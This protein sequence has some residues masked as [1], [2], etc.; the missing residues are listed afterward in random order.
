MAFAARPV[1]QTHLC[2]TARERPR[3]VLRRAST[4]TAASMDPG[5]DALLRLAGQAATETPLWLTGGEPC[6]RADLPALISALAQTGFRVGMVSDGET[7]A[8]PGA[9]EALRDAGLQALR[10][11][12]H[13]ARAD[14]HDWLVGKPGACRSVLRTARRAL[15]L[16]FT[17]EIGATLTRPTA[18]HLA[19]WAQL[20]ARLGAHAAHL[21][22]WPIP[23]PG[24]GDAI[25]LSPRFGLLEDALE[26][27]AA[28]AVAFELPLTLWGLP[29]CVA[30]RLRTLH[31]RRELL[32]PEGAAFATLADP[33]RTRGAC[34]A[35]AVMPECE[36]AP[37]DYLAR[38]GMGEFLSE[39]ARAS[40]AAAETQPLAN[41]ADGPA[42]SARLPTY[43]VAPPPPRALRSPATRVRYGREQA[44]A[45]TLDGDP[46]GGVARGPVPDV[47]RTGWGA[48]SRVA[49]PSCGD[50]GQPLRSARD[51]R[52][53]L[54]LAAQQGSRE[55][56]LASAD[57]FS[58]PE[59]R[60]LLPDATQLAFEHVEVAGEAGPLAEWRDDELA[61]L[62]RF[63]RVRAALYGPDARLHDRHMQCEGAFDAALT[64]LSRLAQKSRV[65]IGCYAVLH[66]PSAV[67]GYAEAWQAGRLP[68]TPAFRL[69]PA[70]SSLNALARAA[71]ELPEGPTRA[72]LAAVLPPCLLPRAE[73]VARPAPAGSSI[74]PTS[75]HT[76]AD[77]GP[78]SG[79][80]PLG[81]FL[82][83]QCGPG[84]AARCPGRAVG[85][86][87]EA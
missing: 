59:A 58:H 57:V 66:D 35:C 9:L 56:R 53:L 83:C 15:E 43:P 71:A 74:A 87:L 11:G 67:A 20:A 73:S 33:A 72:A 17:V 41:A 42:A 78:P 32:L 70:G 52:R 13:S 69:S 46:I 77:A 1:A 34:G 68:G 65:E 49:C 30:P 62:K 29:H 48:V 28:T 76:A 50:A 8:S 36:G 79:S 31:G 27:A 85:W 80:D 10:F 44:A 84:L 75:A 64:G 7:L 39:P 3:G 24:V 2:V 16:G 14:A 37:Q 23:A 6:L 5:R 63:Q 51:N 61:K 82:P 21:T 25:M 60:T 45:A 12:L 86:E 26:A 4:D 47:V 40:A 19:E 81:E 18:P 22:R 55:L 38:F 54:V